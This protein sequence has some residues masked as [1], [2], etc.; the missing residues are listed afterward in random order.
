V[1]SNRSW[2]SYDEIL[3]ETQETRCFGV[4]EWVSGI[5]KEERK[6]GFSYSSGAARISR[7]TRPSDDRSQRN[8]DS[9]KIILSS[10]CRRKKLI[11]LTDY[12]ACVGKA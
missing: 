7:A 3:F 10:Y 6:L 1:R 8:N 4:G 5:S 2:V 9:K 11:R 12:D